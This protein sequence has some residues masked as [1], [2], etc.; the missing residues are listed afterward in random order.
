VMFRNFDILLPVSFSF[1]YDT[2]VP[3]QLNVFTCSVLLLSITI[4]LLFGSF[5]QNAITLDIIII[6]I[7]LY[8]LY[9]I[10]SL[11]C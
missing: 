7:I 6:I 4:L 11:Y 8:F 5:P 10:F 2:E 1:S 9:F 3:R